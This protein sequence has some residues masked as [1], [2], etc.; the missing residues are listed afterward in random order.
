MQPWDQAG[1]ALEKLDNM[2]PSI[3]NRELV[4]Q[5]KAQR[6][7]LTVRIQK[8]DALLNLLEKNPDFVKMVDLSRELI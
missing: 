8:I 5:L 2:N 6:Q 3:R 1:Q 7:E 4:P